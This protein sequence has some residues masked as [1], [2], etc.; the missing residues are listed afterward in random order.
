MCSGCSSELTRH[1]KMMQLESEV[2]AVDNEYL[3]PILQYRTQLITIKLF[4]KMLMVLPTFSAKSRDDFIFGAARYLANTLG[5][6]IQNTPSSNLIDPPLTNVEGKQ[7]WRKA[8]FLCRCTENNTVIYCE[9]MC[10]PI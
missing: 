1:R 5:M 6:L 3:A 7:A 8:T 10:A 2:L 4:R 9:V